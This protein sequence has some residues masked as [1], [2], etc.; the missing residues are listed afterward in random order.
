MWNQRKRPRNA[1]G[2][3][4]S[5]VFEARIAAPPFAPRDY[6]ERR[7]L[8][9]S[10]GRIVRTERRRENGRHFSRGPVEGRLT[11]DGRA[12]QVQWADTARP[13]RGRFTSPSMLLLDDV[14]YL[15]VPPPR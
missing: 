7:T 3:D 10:D 6:E 4:P 8:Q 5:G 2:F 11:F 9:L 12:V 13:S 1:A 14:A 15:R